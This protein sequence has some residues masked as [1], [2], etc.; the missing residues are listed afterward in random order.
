MHYDILPMHYEVFYSVG[1]SPLPCPYLFAF[2]LGRLIGAL[3]FIRVFWMNY[4]ISLVTIL[5]DVRP[6]SDSGF[7]HEHRNARF[8]AQTEH[9]FWLPAD[10]EQVAEYRVVNPRDV[11]G[12]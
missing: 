7:I 4:V 5:G 1:S 11:A 2:F 10:Q 6:D 8:R 9:R 3:F 12:A